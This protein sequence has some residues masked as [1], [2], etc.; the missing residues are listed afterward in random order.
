MTSSTPSNMS[1]VAKH[2]KLGIG[3]SGFVTVCVGM[4]TVG[5]GIGAGCDERDP[6]CSVIFGSCNHVTV[7]LSKSSPLVPSAETSSKLAEGE[8]DFGT[9]LLLAVETCSI[10][11]LLVVKIS[12]MGAVQANLNLVLLAFLGLHSSRY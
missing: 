11:S 4:E 6:C 3:A 2:G 7:L 9:I 8:C 5:C 12:E 1:M 10:V